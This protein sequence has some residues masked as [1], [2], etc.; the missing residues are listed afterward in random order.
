MMAR[1]R[2]NDLHGRRTRTSQ[3]K[4]E[5]GSNGKRACSRE[6]RAE[7]GGTAAPPG[8]AAATSQRHEYCSTLAPAGHTAAASRTEPAAAFSRQ[9][10]AAAASARRCFGSTATAE[11]AA[12]GAQ[13]APSR[14]R[15]DRNPSTTHQPRAW[16]SHRGEPGSRAAGGA[17]E[18]APRADREGHRVAQND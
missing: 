4:R 8:F 13:H 10:T 12:A 9:P 5:S 2:V 15:S 3:R 14:V 7:A 11:R 6:R 1:R 16:D 18:G 17:D